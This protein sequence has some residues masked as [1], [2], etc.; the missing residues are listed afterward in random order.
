[1][2]I[3]QANLPINTSSEQSEQS[4]SGETIKANSRSS[5]PN[6]SLYLDNSAEAPEPFIFGWTSVDSRTYPYPI[7][8]QY[9][10]QI[11]STFTMPSQDNTSS[12]D[13]IPNQSSITQ[14]S[15]H[16]YHDWRLR[17]K[18]SLGEASLAEFILT[19]QA[20]PENLT[21]R[22]KFVTNDLKALSV[23]QSTVDMN[24]FQIIA[25]YDTA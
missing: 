11:E 22:R 12:F 9:I 7:P 4:E 16:T 3:D 24:V 8:S 13:V 23:I 10:S 1:M 2:D 19:D 18:T 5:S 15:K 21:E 6:V 17:L 20:T 14:L 25:Q